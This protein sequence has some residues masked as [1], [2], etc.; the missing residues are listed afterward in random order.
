MREAERGSLRDECDAGTESRTITE[1][2]HHFGSGVAN[3]HTDLGLR[4]IAQPWR[5]SI[6]VLV[7]N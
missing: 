3:D 6:D 2:R 4:D 7:I 5:R 1:G